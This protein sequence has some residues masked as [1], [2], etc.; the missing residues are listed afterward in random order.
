MNTPLQIN[1]KKYMDL[2]NMTAVK[3]ADSVGVERQSVYSWLNGQRMTIDKLFEI[4]GA[5]DC[6][7]ESLLFGEKT[8]D[9]VILTQAI[10]ITDKALG[11]IVVDIEKKADLIAYI[12]EEIS[13]GNKLDDNKLSRLVALMR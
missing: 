10:T 5:L 11:N 4:A 9:T 1:L 7:A 2:R 12:Y 3:L 13:L 8:I 6:S